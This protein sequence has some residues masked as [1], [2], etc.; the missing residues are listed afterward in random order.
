LN[1]P[2]FPRPALS[3]A[4]LYLLLVIHQ[5]VITPPITRI[6]LPGSS[7]QQLQKDGSRGVTLKSMPP[8]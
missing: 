8:A 3:W 6:E 2:S 1:E 5:T 7:A 4:F